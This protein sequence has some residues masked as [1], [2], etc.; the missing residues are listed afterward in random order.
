MTLSACSARDRRG[1]QVRRRERKRKRDKERKEN[2][3]RKGR[4]REE[5][6]LGYRDGR[7]GRG[8]R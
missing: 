5:T 6:M 2:E 4:M 8:V 1:T 7:S 3:E